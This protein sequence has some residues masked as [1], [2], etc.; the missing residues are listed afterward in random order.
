M[1][2]RFHPY[3]ELGIFGKQYYNLE[4]LHSYQQV[5]TVKLGSQYSLDDNPYK[6]APRSVIGAYVA[7]G[8]YNYPVEIYPEIPLLNVHHYP[9]VEYPPIP[10]KD[11]HFRGELYVSTRF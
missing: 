8:F 2:E 4:T 10:R 11:V 6:A 5:F 9:R 3:L 7:V 1:T